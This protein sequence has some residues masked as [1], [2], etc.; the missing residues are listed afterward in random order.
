MLSVALTGNVAAGKSLVSSHWSAAGIPIISA[1][2][3]SRAAVLPGSP[4]LDAVRVAFGAEVITGD[5]TLDREALRALIFADGEARTRL[6]GILHPL[7]WELRA[8]W[9][10]RHR[11]EGA[12]LVV[13][14]IPLLFE[15]GRQGDF[16]VTVLVHAPEDLR[17]DR[18]VQGRGL[19]ENEA[20]GIMAAQMDHEQKRPL[21]DIVIENAGTPADLEAEAGRVL[22]DLLG[23]TP[24]ESIRVDLHLHTAGSWDCLSDPERVLETAIARG[25]ERVAMTDHNRVS[26]A[27]KMAEAYPDRV[28]PGE[29]VRTAEGVDVIGLY[30]S[31]EI[32]KGTPARETIGRIRGQGGIPYLPHPYSGGKSRGGRL[33]DELASLCDI[34]EVFNARL[35]SASANRRAAELATRH[36]KL[37]GAGSDAHTIGELGNAFVDL[38]A[39]PNRPDALLGALASSRTGGSEASRLV[40]LASTWA[41]LR[42]KLPGG[43]TG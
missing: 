17:L 15:T 41:K 27:L 36:D 13:A 25:Y 4:G 32:P 30:L 29:E 40:H 28:I 9:F 23:R 16:D 33:A 3:L 14:E 11:A 34:V 6:E 7:I 35:H 38:P 37:R 31:E 2:D 1:D 19:A 10:E 12:A 43:P 22:S 42:K 39:H 26:V 21:A 5:G 18:L 24:H 8:D 20:R